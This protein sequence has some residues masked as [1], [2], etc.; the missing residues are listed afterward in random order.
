MWKTALTYKLVFD[1]RTTRIEKPQVLE[2]ASGGELSGTGRWQLT[3]QASVTVVRYDWKVSTTKAWMNR[4]APLAR[5]L[6]A[7][8]HKVVMQEGGEALAR[9]LG[10][11]LLQASHSTSTS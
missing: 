7:W 1:L 10:A 8:N 6:F 2:A 11:R 4:L 9:Y 5:P 3:P